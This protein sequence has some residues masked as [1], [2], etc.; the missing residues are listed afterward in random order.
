MPG[1]CSFITNRSGAPVWTAEQPYHERLRSGLIAAVGEEAFREHWQA[2]ECLSLE[3]AIEL[4]L[5]L[6]NFQN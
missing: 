4:A 5:S 1:G 3:D 2:G 6:D